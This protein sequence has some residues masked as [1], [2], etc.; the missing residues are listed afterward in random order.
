VSAHADIPGADETLKAMFARFR[1]A[2]ESPIFEELA[3]ALLARGHANEALQITEHGL[4]KLPTHVGGRIQ[5]AAALIALGRPKVAYIELLRALAI[6]SDNARAQRLLGRVF[7][8]AGAPDRAAKLLAKRHQNRRR[9]EPPKPAVAPVAAPPIPDVDQEETR[10][11]EIPFEIAS[12]PATVAE[13]P[14]PEAHLSQDLL[15]LEPAEPTAKL[16]APTIPR[17]DVANLFAELTKD[18][19]LKP[20]RPVVSRVEVTQVIRMRQAPKPRPHLSSIDGPI[21]DTTHPGELELLDDADIEPIEATKTPASLFDVVTSPHGLAGMSLSDEPLFHE[22]LPFRV[23]AVKEGAE[24]PADNGPKE[25][26]FDVLRRSMTKEVP[27]LTNVDDDERGVFGRE[28]ELPAQ[29]ASAGAAPQRPPARLPAPPEYPRPKLA[30][31][32][33]DGEIAPPRRGPALILT[34]LILFTMAG[35]VGIFLFL[36]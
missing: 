4:Q 22:D 29:P 35:L 3:E 27:A 26:D 21:V 34:L 16:S 18:L 28:A 31:E 30:G 13:T 24:G 6:E 14:G 8:E 33:A 25:V 32:E 5:R 10:R 12:K 36:R 19:G 11:I 20:E 15:P 7:V 23:D 17:A 9:E 1:A 2:P